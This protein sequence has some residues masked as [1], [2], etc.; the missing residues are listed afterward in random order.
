MEIVQLGNGDCALQTFRR[1]FVEANFEERA[2][3]VAMQSSG[4]YLKLNLHVLGNYSPD[5]R[6]ARERKYQ[7]H[8][9][10]NFPSV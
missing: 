5:P 1:G 10:F 2:A 8:K 7:T 3:F 4:A 9:M 6:A